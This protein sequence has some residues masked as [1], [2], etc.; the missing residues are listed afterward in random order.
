MPEIPP[1]V[2][3]IVK[4]L[5]HSGATDV[6]IVGGF[7][8]DRLLGIRSK[9]V[10]VEVYGLSYAQ[11]IK[12]L[13]PHFHVDLVGQSFGVIKV[14]NIVDV[15]LPR[16]ESKT[17][18]GHKG[19]DVESVSDLSPKEA[20]SRRDFTINAIGMRLD[21]S[22][23]DP[24]DGIGDLKRK[25]LR[26]TSPAFKD[27]PLRVLRGMQFASR[28]G[29][30][31]DPQTL[32]Y[33]REVYHEFPALS[34]ERVYEEW[35]KWALKGV[36]PELGLDMLY[37]CGWI[38]AFPELFALVGCPQNS[39]RRPEE[40]VWS[41]TKAVC[42]EAVNLITGCKPALSDDERTIL[43]LAAL[44]HDFGKPETTTYD[45]IGMVRSKGHAA[46]GASIAKHFLENLNAPK[47][48]VGAVVPLVAEHMAIQDVG[49]NPSPRD[50]RRLAR[51]LEPANIKLW[52][53]LCQSNAPTDWMN[54]RGDDLSLPPEN[55]IESKQIE[56]KIRFQAEQWLAI[57]RQHK[58]LES[59][60]RPLVQGRDLLALGLKPG[61]HIGVI[62][63][64]LFEEQIDGVFATKDEGVAR[65]KEKL[66]L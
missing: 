38:R 10:D 14:G 41:H 47:R 24:Y 57:A 16:R 19:F 59:G 33:C 61:P 46:A 13:S 54:R 51:K 15:A 9:D 64:E 18:L 22:Y 42:R 34:K 29:L 55:E 66:G 58:V 65:L 48:I 39:K 37:D 50:I 25:V 21:G 53:L 35:K 3:N 44:C 49:D 1:L 17:G 32:Q 63:K 27:D 45:E 5:E 60:P 26:A 8:R 30:K 28:F 12:A 20:F 40:D 52:A 2:L 23:C 62:L 36:Q 43:M 11:I 4:L 56:R 31:M 6:L 7:V